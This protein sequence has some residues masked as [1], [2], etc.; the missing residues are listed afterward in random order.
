MV[1]GMKPK[2]NVVT[3]RGSGRIDARAYG[4]VARRFENGSFAAQNSDDHG[5]YDR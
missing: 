2:H 4:L 5:A 3:P 1:K